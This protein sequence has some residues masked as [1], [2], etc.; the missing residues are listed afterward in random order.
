[1]AV[2][3]QYFLKEQIEKR[4]YINIFSM[5]NDSNHLSPKLNDW[6]IKN[7]ALLDYITISTYPVY[8]NDLFQM[9]AI[10]E[11]KRQTQILKL[12]KLLELIEAELDSLQHPEKDQKPSLDSS[13]KSL[14]F[15]H[16]LEYIKYKLYKM[17]KKKLVQ[18]HLKIQTI[19]N[20]FLDQNIL[21]QSIDLSVN[22]DKLENDIKNMTSKY[23]G[24]LNYFKDFKNKYMKSLSLPATESQIKEIMNTVLS[25]ASQNTDNMN[26]LPL[27]NIQ[28]KFEQIIFCNVSPFLNE[29]DDI[30]SSF[31]TKTKSEFSNNLMELFYHILQFYQISG[32]VKSS[33]CFIMVFRAMFSRAYTISPDFFYEKM[34][35]FVDI[36]NYFEKIP[37]S[38]LDLPEFLIPKDKRC[39]LI[40]DF[41]SQNK[42]F[43]KGG[44]RL[45]FSTFY[46]NPIDPIFEIYKMLKN[47]E[48]GA[49]SIVTSN[50]STSLFEFEINFGL[51]LGTLISSHIPNFEQLAKFVMS[52][53]PKDS[54]SSELQFSLM[55]TSAVCSYCDTIKNSFSK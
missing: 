48:K 6:L 37:C 21:S 8:N 32:S 54:L 28:Q 14:W 43:R 18:N 52:F 7:V 49:K 46:T 34:D 39:L 22:F 44:L 41:F 29:I 40:K 27:S 53:A 36:S 10:I 16:H 2:C 45:I 55:T 47:I 38:Y 17:K 19:L 33:C 23:F 5:D 3:I 25:F 12:S 24:L 4:R 50:T 9:N 1:M 30:L 31:M 11:M 15:Y 35:N 51:Y 26:Y 20:L 42:Y 13:N